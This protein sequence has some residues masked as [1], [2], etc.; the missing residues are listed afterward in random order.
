MCKTTYIETVTIIGS[1]NVAAHLALAFKNIGIK[2]SQICSRNYTEAEIIAKNV[3][4]NAVCNLSKINTT[5]DYYFV[6]VSD[7]AISEVV[8]KMPFVSGVVA[9]T[10]GCIPISKLEKFHSFGS[11]YPLQTF[12]KGSEIDFSKIYIFIEGNSVKTEQKLLNIATK[13]TKNVRKICSEKREVLHLA[14]TISCNFVNHLYTISQHIVEDAGLSFDFLKPII[15]ET[16]KKACKINPYDAQTGPAKR[17][18]YEVLQIHLKKLC[19]N[20]KFSEIYSKISESIMD[21]N[22]E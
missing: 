22:Y 12:T 9:H 4:A 7:S 19:Y 5:S 1:G 6:A 11:F 3:G 14:S 8:E 21:M 17:K 10:A 13:L 15:E 18:D 2:I 20:E 16:A